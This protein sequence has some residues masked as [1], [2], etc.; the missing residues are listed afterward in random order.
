MTHEQIVDLAK[1]G[2]IVIAFLT[3]VYLCYLTRFRIK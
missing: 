1:A 2:G 3:G